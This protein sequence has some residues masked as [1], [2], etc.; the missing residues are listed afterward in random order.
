[1][2]LPTGVVLLPTGVVLLPTGVVLLPTG[3]VLLP[4]GVVLAGFILIFYVLVNEISY[5]SIDIGA[6]VLVHIVEYVL[7]KPM[8]CCKECISL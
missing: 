4:T 3:V 7:L 5:F 2:L 6:T 1:V 8:S